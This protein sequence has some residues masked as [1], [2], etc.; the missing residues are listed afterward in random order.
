M[1]YCMLKCDMV[2]LLFFTTLRGEGPRIQKL[3]PFAENPP[4]VYY[5]RPGVAKI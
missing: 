1:M 2:T 4:K 3:K 5:F